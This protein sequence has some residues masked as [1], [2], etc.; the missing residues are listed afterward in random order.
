MKYIYI[1]ALTLGCSC[2]VKDRAG[3]N[4]KDGAAGRD[5]D[6]A[7]TQRVEAL[8][9]LYNAL[10]STVTLLGAEVA[11]DNARI[12]DLELINQT[13]D[14]AF[15]DIYARLTALEISNSTI[16]AQIADIAA[17]VTVLQSIADTQISEVIDP[18][19]DG[20]YW[21]EVLLKLGNGQIVAYFENGGNR[22]LTVLS[23]GHYETTDA[24]RCRFTVSAGGVSW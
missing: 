21:D 10:N 18:C 24:Q 5:A 15:T 11:S 22:F 6:P 4:G 13:Y 17:D 3:I 14:S 9:Q 2:V 23:N 7:L 19:G 1:L 8:E 20:A 16:T 12:E